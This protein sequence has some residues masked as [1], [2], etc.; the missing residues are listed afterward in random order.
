MRRCSWPFCRATATFWF[1]AA[2]V[3]FVV[4][5]VYA[6][7]PSAAQLKAAEALAR[8]G[9][10]YVRWDEETGSPSSIEEQR[11]SVGA[12]YRRPR[13]FAAKSVATSF[14]SSYAGLFPLRQGRDSL[15]IVQISDPPSY[16]KI[17]TVRTEQIYM[18][19]PVEGGG[20]TVSVSPDGKVLALNGRFYGGIELVPSPT[21]DAEEA[22]R[23]ARHEVGAGADSVLRPVRL[24]VTR[25]E[26][27]DHLVWAAT[28]PEDPLHVWIV[29]VDAHDGKVI[30]RTNRVIVD[31][32]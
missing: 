18:G 16:H 15:A 30:R 7:L 3:T 29:Q 32:R 26:G 22:A 10:W 6:A 17:S 13:P 31:P 4:P 24:A 19:L 9:D 23:I 1:I 21:I 25:P 14:I 8:T 5:T 12:A 11:L 2:V 20:Y 28:V 27:Q